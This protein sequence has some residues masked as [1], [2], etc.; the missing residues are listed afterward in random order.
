MGQQVAVL[1]VP[2]ET[3]SLSVS[4]LRI[5]I[6]GSAALNGNNAV[7][8]LAATA[9]GGLSFANTGGSTV[10]GTAGQIPPDALAAT[11]DLWQRLRAWQSRTAD[12]L[13]LPDPA[14]GL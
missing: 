12:T 14:A 3:G 11:R 4:N 8:T 1:A 6:T 2:A 13:R 7:G 9:P 5:S 10:G